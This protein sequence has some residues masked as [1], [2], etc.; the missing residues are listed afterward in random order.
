VATLHLP[1]EFK[2]VENV[3]FITGSQNGCIRIWNNDIIELRNIE[4]A[5][6][7]IIRSFC[8]NIYDLTFFSASNDLFIKQ[9]TIAGDLLRNFT[10]HFGFIFNICISKTSE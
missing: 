8:Y 4:K 6:D 10:G 2:E 7:D 1:I 5:H 3:E 9:W